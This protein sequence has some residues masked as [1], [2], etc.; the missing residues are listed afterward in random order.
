MFR[1]PDAGAKLDATPRQLVEGSDLLGQA[2]G[3]V[4]GELIDHHADA[5]VE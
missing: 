3:V 2:H 1:H 5:Q 4:K